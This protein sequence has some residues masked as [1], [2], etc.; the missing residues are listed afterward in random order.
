MVRRLILGHKG[1]K[2]KGEQ[3]VNGADINVKQKTGLVYAH[4]R[5]N[6]LSQL[7]FME[8]NNV[9]MVEHPPFNSS[10]NCNEEMYMY[11]HKRGQICVTIS[12]P[13]EV[14]DSKFRREKQQRAMQIG[15]CSIQPIQ[16]SSCSNTTVIAGTSD[17]VH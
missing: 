17:K 11:T 12:V 10:E 13:F 1:L 15:L 4:S 3:T 9:Q 5:E 6:A 16:Y 7:M 2:V 8:I 14:A